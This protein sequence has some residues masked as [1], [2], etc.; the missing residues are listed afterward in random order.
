MSLDRAEAERITAFL[1][2]DA[3]PGRADLAFVFGTRRLEPAYLAA[4]LFKHGVVENVVL[5]GGR[6]RLS[7]RGEATT[8]L[9]VLLREGIPRSKIIVEGESTN[10]LQN[11]TFALPKIAVRL[12]LGVLRSVVVVAKWYHCRRAMMAL[13]RHL[14]PGVRFFSRTYEPAGF[15]RSSWYLD[16]GAAERVLAEYRR[17]SGY[18]ERGHISEIRREAVGYV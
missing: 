7:G 17:I 8:H 11:V 18:L 15:S 5:T 10:T 1:S 9:G 13:K 4:G 3:E 12:D 2:A 6:N 16:Q 14:P